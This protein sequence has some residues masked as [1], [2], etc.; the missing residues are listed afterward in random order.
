M[1]CISVLG[2]RQAGFERRQLPNT[3][4]NGDLEVSGNRYD[5]NYYTK[6]YSV[7]V[8]RTGTGTVSAGSVEGARRALIAPGIGALLNGVPSGTSCS[9]AH[10][11]VKSVFGTG[12]MLL[13]FGEPGA[14][15][16]DVLNSLTSGLGPVNALGSS[17][18]PTVE[19][20]NS[21]NVTTGNNQSIYICTSTLESLQAL[22][23]SS[24]TIKFALRN[25]T[26]PLP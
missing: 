16:N 18:S 13:G 19:T 4:V 15:L 22:E 17:R 6:A 2:G 14:K 25:P 20:G 8:T 21:A 12:A 10:V 23:N 11:N 5:G 1:V 24:A 9:Y 7:T 3:K 26:T